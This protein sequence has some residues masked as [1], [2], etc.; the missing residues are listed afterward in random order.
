MTMPA[1]SRKLSRR[2]RCAVVAAT[3]GALILIAFGTGSAASA[4]PEATAS[5]SVTVKIRSFKFKPHTIR[6]DRGDRVVWVNRDTVK[7]T[8]TRRGSFTTG[9]IKPG[10]AVAIRFGSKG[11]YR[12]VCS[13][14]P[15]MVGKVVVG[16]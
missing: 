7:H 3:G 5:R 6:I 16:G 10:R 9:R 11:T 14:H 1:I 2:A 8:A 15:E 13:I 4:A 12:Y